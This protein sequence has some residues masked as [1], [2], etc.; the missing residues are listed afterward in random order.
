[1]YR[2]STS[3]FSIYAKRIL[4]SLSTTS[5]FL[6]IH[7]RSQNDLI[8]SVPLLTCASILPIFSQNVPTEAQKDPTFFSSYSKEIINRNEKGIHLPT[9]LKNKQ[10][11]N[12][13]KTPTDFTR[14]T[15]VNRSKQVKSSN[16]KSRSTCVMPSSNGCCSTP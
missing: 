5:L 12:P 6:E 10:T 3:T 7:N 14:L 9:A 8:L 15:I 16:A 4:F 1:M 11:K 2:C 13:N